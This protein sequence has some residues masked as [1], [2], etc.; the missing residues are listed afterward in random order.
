LT[1][2]TLVNEFKRQQKESWFKDFELIG[3]L[4]P[5]RLMQGD[6][7]MLRKTSGKAL[8]PVDDVIQFAG[9]DILEKE[10]QAIIDRARKTSK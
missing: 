4:E 3:L 2:L 6:F 10:A 7:I 1:S 8:E 9:A 5:Q